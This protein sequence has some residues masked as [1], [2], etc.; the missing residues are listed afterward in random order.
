MLTFSP[1]K[2]TLLQTDP[3]NLTAL[4]GLLYNGLFQGFLSNVL[5]TRQPQIYDTLLHMRWTKIWDTDV[6][7]VWECVLFV[8]ANAKRNL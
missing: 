3:Q 7:F 4:E 6:L 8:D 2:R 1:N 5:K